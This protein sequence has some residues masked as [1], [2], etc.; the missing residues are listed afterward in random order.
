MSTERILLII[1]GL[2]IF[3]LLWL[4]Y[5][6]LLINSR[7]DGELGEATS[8]DRARATEAIRQVE[9]CA[10]MNRDDERR[11]GICTLEREAQWAVYFDAICQCR[12]RV[13]VSDFE[14]KST[15][16]PRAA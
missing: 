8:A 13:L 11:R 6:L 4:V 14:T 12:D 5:Q 10:L 9:A 16:R 2:T 3:C 15:L 1:A 7:V